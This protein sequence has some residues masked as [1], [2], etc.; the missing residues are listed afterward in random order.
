MILRALLALFFV[1]IGSVILGASESS[2]FVAVQ[3]GGLVHG[4]YNFSWAWW[5]R[6]TLWRDKVCI[7]QCNIPTALRVR[8]CID[9]Y[10]ISTALACDTMLR[11]SLTTHRKPCIRD[12]EGLNFVRSQEGEAALPVDQ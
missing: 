2:S 12:L 5:L 3:S 1:F 8:V 4:R 11:Y 6:T 9:L 10:N 7:V